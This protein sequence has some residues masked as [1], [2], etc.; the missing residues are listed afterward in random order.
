V[1]G[2]VKALIWAG[3]FVAAAG[4]GA[5]V[6]AH[7]NPFPPGVEDPGT[8]GSGSPAAQPQRWLFV[9][10]THAAHRLRVGGT[11][12]A[13]WRTASA[14]TIDPDGTVAGSGRAALRGRARCP[15]HTAQVPARGV[16]VDVRGH[17][18]G[19]TM[20][21]RISATGPPE[22]PGS[23][24]LGGF[25]SSLATVTLRIEGSA[26]SGTLARSTPDGD[27]GRFRSTA[28]ARARCTTCVLP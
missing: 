19:T 15:F 7:T 28:R 18:R 2:W 8:A 25:A 27:R 4:A 20:V 17:V 12:R 10:T 22:P 13:T 24:D 3:V 9:M 23:V 5:F 21:L 1:R 6:A 14:L 16:P 26:A 11:C